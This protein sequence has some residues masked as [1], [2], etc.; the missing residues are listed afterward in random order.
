MNDTNDVFQTMNDKESF[1]I[2]QKC[3]YSSFKFCMKREGHLEQFDFHIR[4]DSVPVEVYRFPYVPK[5]WECK[6]NN[7]LQSLMW[8]NF[9]HVRFLFFLN[10]FFLHFFFIWRIIII[11]LLKI[12]ILTARHSRAT[13]GIAR[14][15]GLKQPSP[16]PKTPLMVTIFALL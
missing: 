8:P 13:L 5:L 16:C 3:N 4:R 7:W 1:Y 6:A 14:G 2:G 12:K 15:M 10:E 9:N 11:Y